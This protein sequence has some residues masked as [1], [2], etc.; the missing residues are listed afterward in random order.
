M[1]EEISEEKLARLADFL[2]EAG[3]LRAI[4]RSGYA[5]LGSGGESVAEHSFR[6]SV[7]GFILA[8]L[9]GV[10]PAKAVFL[11]LFHDFHEARTGDFNYVNHRYNDCKAREALKDATGGTGLE[12]EILAYWDELEKVDT[13]D[14]KIAADAD[15]LDLL[16]NLA[17][18]L[19][20]GNEYAREWIN[21]ALPRLRLPQS[22]ELATAILKTDPSHWWRF[23]VRPEWWIDRGKK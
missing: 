7:I 16:C 15:Q 14:A 11:C 18:E 23:D 9:C 2:Y 17:Q 12:G 19:A 8:R 22:R 3:M 21:A 10:E 4:N 1:A 20:K 5:F 6:A 13:L